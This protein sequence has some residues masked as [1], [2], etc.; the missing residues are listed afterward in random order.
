MKNIFSKIAGSAVVVAFALTIVVAPTASALTA[1]DIQ[2][3]VSMGV[4]PADKAAAAMAAL[5]TTTSTS[6]T[7]S[8]GT[9]TRDLTLGSTGADVVSLQSFLEAKGT[10]SIPAGTS[11]GY[12]GA[13][14]QSA[15]AKYQA[16]VMISP[17]AGYFGPVTRAK[18]A[19]D[20]TTTTTTTTTTTSGSLNGE[21][22]RLS[23][24]DRENSYSNEDLEEGETAK[25]FAAEFEVEDGDVSID[26]VDIRLES[27]TETLEDEPWNQIESIA[28]FI[29][30]D[31]VDSMDV[32]SEDDWSREDSTETPTTSRAYEVRFAGLDTVVEEGDDALIEVEVTTSDS[33][34]DS[35]LTQSWKIWIPTDGIRAVD[36][37]GIDH[38]EGSNTESTEFEIEAADAGDVTIRSSDDDLDASILVVDT[39]DNSGPFEV[40]RFEIDNDDSADV[41]LNTLTIIASTTD[42]DV[43]DVVIDL[44]IEIDGQEFDY[45][46]ASTTAGV[47]EYTFDFE[48]NGD[49]IELE[50]DSRIEVVVMAEFNS[51]GSS[52]A[53]FD[54]GESVQFGVGKING[55]D[56]GTNALTAEGAANGDSSVVSGTQEGA[57]HTLR[58]TG[59]VVE[60]V[61]EGSSL[62]ENVD[63][64][65]TDNEGIYTFEIRITALEEDAW[66]YDS[67]STT[68]SS[69]A[70][71][72]AT[73]TGSTFTG[74]SSA[75][76]SDTS[77]DVETNDRY[78]VAEGTSETFEII[79]EL[80]PGTTGQY[81]LELD[82]I[83]FATTSTATQ[84]AYTVPD[85]SEYSIPTQTI[86]N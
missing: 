55:S 49:E 27:V 29:N 6:S 44:T 73:V 59:I 41:L 57:T 33:I 39:D 58:T 60:G 47:G 16:S 63:T 79:V 13:L 23:S 66:I 24:Y 77:A 22:A 19:G 25:V 35:D 14:T 85:E 21:E 64:T 83:N 10:L 86:K 84:A 5:S 52:F 71:F 69:T 15:L 50:K 7:A 34:D 61:S 82:S 51:T 74:T 67:V 70:G 26:R 42:D 4:I 38:Y 53:N 80:D 62:R 20:C 40:F 48:D 32:D 36:G 9:Y 56:F 3:L 37:K 43:E 8:C 75:R 72:V 78:K 17:A 11:K 65:L 28:L 2:L 18:V 68:S 54:N 76:I 12:F 46:T 45:D 31:E 1:A 81:G 30:G